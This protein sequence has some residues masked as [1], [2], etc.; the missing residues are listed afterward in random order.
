MKTIGMLGGMSWE[1]T[2]EYYRYMNQAIKEKLGD[3]HSV[4]CL[5]YSFDFHQMKILQHEGKWELL[6]QQMVDQA[7][8]LKKAGADFIV[9][10]TNTMHLMAPD[11][12]RETGLKVLHIADAAG[13]A[14]KRLDIQTVALLGT[15]FTMEGTFYK[16]VLKNHH[17]IETIIPEKR[18]RQIVH[19]IIYNQLIK[20]DIRD[21]SRDEYIRII[22]SLAEQGAQG[23]ILGCTEIP[24]LIHQKDVSIPVFDTTRIHSIAAV[25]WAIH[26]SA[27]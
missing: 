14:I 8:N 23:V 20:G 16:D 3:S 4:Q 27:Y 19:D 6:T 25:E 21:D 18:D 15:Q 1:S 17:G 13:M 7:M 9:I 24:L 10:C 12:E 11:I 5:L 22:E 2:L 26:S